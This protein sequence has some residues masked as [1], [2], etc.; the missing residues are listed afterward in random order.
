[1]NNGVP[2]RDGQNPNPKSPSCFTIGCFGLI[3]FWIICGIIGS[4]SSAFNK[5]KPKSE[6]ASN[7]ETKDESSTRSSSSVG[8]GQIGYLIL[9][10]DAPYVPVMR[11]R[12][13]LN[14][15]TKCIVRK[16]NEGLAQLYLEGKMLEVETRCPVRILETGGFLSGVY[17]IRILGGKNYGRDGWVHYEC[18]KPSK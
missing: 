6:V 11:T 5:D 9:D 4:I 15:F 12:E 16:D 14:E 8:L 13:A 3:G 7:I 2:I 18:V 10:P 17:R 1:M